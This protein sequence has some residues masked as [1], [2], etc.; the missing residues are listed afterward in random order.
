MSR[1][2]ERR[3][4]ARAS[5]V[6]SIANLI[7]SSSLGRW[8]SICQRPQQASQNG[9]CESRFGISVELKRG[10][11]MDVGRQLLLS[12]TPAF[13]LERCL[14]FS[15]RRFQT[16]RSDELNDSGEFVSIEPEAMISTEIDNDSGAACKVS[17]VHQL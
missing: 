13:F 5:A 3:R 12:Q 15:A 16:T 8:P 10:G 11:L 4:P 14:L 9:S 17:P 1:R 7:E 2:D 6:G